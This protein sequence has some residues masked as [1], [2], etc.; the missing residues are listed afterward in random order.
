MVRELSRVM[1]KPLRST[2]PGR[3]SSCR[4]NVTSALITT[5]RVITK[6]RSLYARAAWEL[7]P[8]SDGAWFQQAKSEGGPGRLMDA[9]DAL[10]RAIS[11]NPRASF[12][13]ITFCPTSTGG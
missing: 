2:R 7:E 1:R 5:G 9:V 4:R 6:K 10:H 8:K 12:R 13:I 3:G 11:I